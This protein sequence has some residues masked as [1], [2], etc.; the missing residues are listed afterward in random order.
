M[1]ICRNLTIFL[2]FIVIQNYP[3]NVKFHSRI[4]YKDL[5]PGFHTR[6]SYQDFIPGF[7]TRILYQD[8][9]PGFHT[10]ISYQDFIPGFHTRIS[11]QDFIPGFHTRIHTRMSWLL[12]NMSMTHWRCSAGSWDNPFPLSE[13]TL[14]SFIELI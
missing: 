12:W 14:K 7:H 8:F 6:I 5:I 2:Y 4:S 9:I 1:S 10:R 11:Y 13:T 3:K